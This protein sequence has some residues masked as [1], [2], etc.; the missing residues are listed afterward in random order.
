MGVR[1]IGFLLS[2]GAIS[3][4]SGVNPDARLISKQQPR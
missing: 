3:G 1:A 4:L 2:C